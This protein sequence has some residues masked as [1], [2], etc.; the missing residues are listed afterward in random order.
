[1]KTSKRGFTLPELVVSLAITVIVISLVASLVAIV[2]KVSAKQTHQNACQAEY[3]KASELVALYVDT[4]STQSFDI[5]EV[6]E[7]SVTVTN[8]ENSYS[9]TYD[10]QTKKLEAVT[11]E[12]LTGEVKRHSIAFEKITQIKFTQNGKIILCEYMYDDFPKYSKI[13]TFGA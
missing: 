11:I 8:G 5:K 6:Q 9:L 2:S 3:I 4:F 13:V 10:A 7:N 12:F 1:M